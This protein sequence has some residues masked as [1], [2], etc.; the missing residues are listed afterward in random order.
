MRSRHVYP[1]MRRILGVVLCMAAVGCGGAPDT[2]PRA[3]PAATAR[4]DVVTVTMRHKRFLPRRV[5]VRLGQTV[6]WTNDDPFAHTVASQQLRLAS[7]AIR[8]GATFAYRPLRRGRFAYFCTIHAH[9]TGM[10]IVR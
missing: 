6:R 5:V 3:S 4:P 1:S 7:D 2:A 9:Q 10:L 8:G